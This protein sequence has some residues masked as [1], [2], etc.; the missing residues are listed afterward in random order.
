M[1]E[2]GRMEE[3]GGSGDIVRSSLGYLGGLGVT[4][5]GCFAAGRLS[6]VFALIDRDGLSSITPIWLLMGIGVGVPLV[7]ASMAAGSCLGIL[8]AVYLLR[9]LF[10]FPSELDTVRSVLVFLAVAGVLAPLLSATL[11][12]LILTLGGVVGLVTTARV[13]SEFD[14]SPLV[15]VFVTDITR[16]AQSE[17][18]LRESERKHRFLFES[19]IQGVVYQDREGRIISCNPAAERILGRRFDEMRD[20]TSE[21]PGW[22][23]VHE[24]G[25][26]IPGYEHPSMAALR[27]GRIVS[28]RIMGIYNPRT[29]ERRWIRIDAVPQFRGVEEQPYQVFTTFE[30]I[31]ERRRS[32]QELIASRAKLREL[33]AHLQKSL[34]EERVNMAREIHDGLG[35]IL[36]ALIDQ[37][38]VMVKRMCGELRPGILD[39]FGLIAA[40]QWYSD[41]FTKRSG[42]ECRLSVSPEDIDV[43]RAL[44]VTIYRVVQEAL[45][46]VRRHAGASAVRVSVVRD[47]G[48]LV[49]EIQDDGRGASNR[50]L[51]KRGSFGIIGMRERVLAQEGRLAIEGREGRGVLIRAVF[52]LE[53]EREAEE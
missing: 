46:N 29:D 22:S 10:S 7:S 30:D 31:T 6:L 8:A 13:A 44:A 16:R 50:E 4:A 45:T 21:D 39:D 48:A 23:G 15:V 9:R 32:E 42:V 1:D 26:P 35:Q 41:E 24:D 3:H 27:T 51:E 36:T 20:Q 43:D 18:Q 53:N 52:P 17:S 19:M 33:A 40:L 5:A 28:D 47:G 2:H 12:V 37:G 49:L 38:T 25:T 34:E 11:N 14:A